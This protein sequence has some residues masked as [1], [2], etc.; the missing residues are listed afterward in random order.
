MDGFL[1]GPREIAMK[2][3]VNGGR[4]SA[5]R[6]HLSAQQ[7]SATGLR[8]TRAGAACI[9][10]PPVA[11]ASEQRDVC[12]S[13]DRAP[14]MPVA[15]TSSVSLFN[16]EVRVDLSFLR[17]MIASARDGRR[18]QMFPPGTGG[19]DEFPGGLG[20]PAQSAYWRLRPA[21]AH[22]DGRRQ[23][24]GERSADGV[25]FGAKDPIPTRRGRRAPQDS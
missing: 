5:Q 21:S 18:L 20:R 10:W 23:E 1:S 19:V 15:G 2:V 14:R 13:P 12:R 8:W 11:E 17:G 6:L 25:A 16:G 22:P 24:V 7:L 4:A 3:H 9:W